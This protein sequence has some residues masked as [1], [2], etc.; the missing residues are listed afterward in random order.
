MRMPIL[1]AVLLALSMSAGAQTLYKYVDKDGK[2]TYTDKPPKD[3]ERAEPIKPAT[4]GNTIQSTS[5]GSTAKPPPR[6]GKPADSNKTIDLK[7]KTEARNA[8]REKLLNEVKAAEDALAAAKKALEEGSEPRPDEQ[9]IIVKK[10]GNVVLRSDAYR[11]RIDALEAA[12]KAAEKR[13]E[14]AERNL[15][16]G[17]PD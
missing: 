1:L 6:R 12:I 7:K 13:L 15:R 17:A 10:E 3:G 4:S 5:P 16:R 14:D 2:V 9:R 8:T 11:Q